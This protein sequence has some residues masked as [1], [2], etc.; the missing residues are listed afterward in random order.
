MKEEGIVYLVGAGPGDP[1]LL[2]LR[3][4]EALRAADLVAYDRLV[5]PDLLLHA[6]DDAVK[7]FVGKAPGRRAFTQD[8][9]NDLLVRA[10]G[11]G[12]VV[13]RLKGGDPFVFGRG[14]E[15]AE[16]LR[17]AGV[18]FEVVPGVTSAV[19]APAYAGIPVTH[20]GVASDFAVVTGHVKD[21]EEE[22]DWASL[23]GIDT[24]VI[25]MGLGRLE[26]IARSLVENGRP[27]DTPVA[28]IRSATTSSQ[29]VV[30]GTLSDI[31][32]KAAHLSP[33][34]VIVVGEVV[35]MREKLDWF[36]AGVLG[37]FSSRETWPLDFD[38]NEVVENKEMANEPVLNGLMSGDGFNEEPD[39]RK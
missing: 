7:V 6:P 38:A 33:P 3:G 17:R 28:V 27:A 25:L 26:R 5:H 39:F 1:G 11:A 12:L 9:I 2:T 23:S 30:T 18:P 35:R 20:R 29:E 34:A 24:L 15:E 32:L 36:G 13:V 14:A 31:A 22:P 37:P 4:Q 19:A 8:E 10:G 16:A 21:P